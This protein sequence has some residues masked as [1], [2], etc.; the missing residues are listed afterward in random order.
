VDTVRFVPLTPARL[1]AD[2]AGWINDLEIARPRIGIDG[3]VEVGTA[4]LADAVAA[5]L[6]PLGR[7]A[8]RV[9][10][11]WWWRPASLRLEFGKTDVDM[12]LGGWV[13]NAALRRE[14]LDP[15][16]PSGTG[17]FLRRL[18]DPVTGRSIREDR[19]QAGRQDVLLLDGPFLQADPLPLDAV[20]H[21]QVSRATLARSLPADRQWWLAAFDR[22]QIDDQP[23][24]KAAA[25]VAYDHPAAPAVSWAV[26][27]GPHS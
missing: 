23:A 14:L 18:R 16:G 5:E 4:E 24:Q 17:R 13:D 7:S 3:P 9:S 12:L 6:P 2:L 1:A 10:T 22:Y 25:I 20:V 19:V 8:V 21:I 26:G 27:A 15:F 11:N